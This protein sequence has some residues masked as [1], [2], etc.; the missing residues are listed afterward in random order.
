[1]TRN[2]SLALLSLFNDFLTKNLGLYF[3]KDKWGELEQTMDRAAGEFGYKNGVEYIRALISLPP[4]RERIESLAGYLTVGETYFFRDK[5]FFSALEFQVLPRLIQKH[6]GQ[7]RPLNIWNAAC[8]SG[9]EPYSIAIVLYKLEKILKG[10]QTF[11]LGTDIDRAA[12]DKAGKGIYNKWSFRDFPHWMRP[13]YFD[14]LETDT[15]RIQSHIK[16]M[17]T[18]KYHNLADYLCPSPFVCGQVDVI[19]WRNVLMYLAPAVIGKVVQMFRR[20]LVDDGLLL[21]SPTDALNFPEGS[22]FY[23]E[24]VDPPIFRK[25][26]RPS[27][28]E[29]GISGSVS[30]PHQAAQILPKGERAP[31]VRV[32]PD[33]PRNSD[34]VPVPY[35]GPKSRFSDAL[36]LFQEG[37]YL[38][39]IQ[40]L[41]A[42]AVD[43][44]ESGKDGGIADVYELLARCYANL[45]ESDNALIWC[46]KAVDADS[47]NAQFRYLLGMIFMELDKP[48]DAVTSLKHAL[49]L[50]PGFIPANFMLGHLAI[51]SMDFTGGRR[52]F[53]YTLELLSAF[54]NDAPVPGMEDGLTSGRLQEMIRNMIPKE[55]GNE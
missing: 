32:S 46:R 31:R 49:Y 23:Q 14:C 52:H 17:V 34:S 53:T 9:E 41:E 25:G 20:C 28:Q 7:R 29:A 55:S 6:Y 24:Q 42:L 48:D 16:D 10:L 19:L 5:N 36:G 44:P 37:K 45:G 13:L 30:R 40:L 50:E 15:Y 12:L 3:S 38:G 39:T 51:R 22:G 43:F 8:S 33:S 18:F 26:S 54:P 27:S 1:M 2:E 47:L 11:I 4:S 35:N 21:I